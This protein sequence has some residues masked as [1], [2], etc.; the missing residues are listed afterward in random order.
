[1]VKSY[2]KMTEGEKR[3]SYWDSV[4]LNAE[5]A[6]NATKEYDQDL[7]EAIWEG[8][9]GSQWVIYTARNLDVL[10]FSDSEPESYVWREADDWREAIQGMAFSMM[11]KDVREKVNE[12]R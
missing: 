12:L 11:E 1:M 9:D 3:E 4:K 2:G 5:E 7:S 6:I 10:R 8:V